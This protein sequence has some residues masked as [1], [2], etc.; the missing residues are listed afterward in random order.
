MQQYIYTV[1]ALWT[2]DKSQ[3]N[4]T[5]Y[6]PQYKGKNNEGK[7]LGKNSKPRT[8]PIA[9]P[10]RYTYIYT[11]VLWTPDK[12]WCNLTQYCEQYNNYEGNKLRPNFK[13]TKDAHS[14]P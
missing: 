12:S 3:C 4:I 7:N 2:T 9:R 8:T 10:D 13:L 6:C 11:E 1:V 5:R 14:S